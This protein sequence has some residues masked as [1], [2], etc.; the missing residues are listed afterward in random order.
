TSRLRRQPNAR[1]AS[2]TR[3]QVSSPNRCRSPRR[4]RDAALNETFAL[5]AT[6]FNRGTCEELAMSQF[7]SLEGKGQERDSRRTHLKQTPRYSSKPPGGASGFNLHWAQRAQ[8]L[9][10][11]RW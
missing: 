5:A 3:S 10:K 6:S 8:L 4:I 2:S 9:A 7:P 11:T 1:A